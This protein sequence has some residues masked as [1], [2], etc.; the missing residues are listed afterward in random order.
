MTTRLLAAVETPALD[1]W[2]AQIRGVVLGP[3]TAYEWEGKLDGFDE[4]SGLRDADIDRPAG[5][6]AFSMIDYAQP[7]TIAFTLEAADEPDL[8]VSLASAL[9]DL[10]VA[11]APSETAETVPFWYHLPMLGMRRADVKVRRRRVAVDDRYE[12]GVVLVDVQL[13]APDPFLY[14]PASTATTTFAALAGGLEF[15][16]FSD[17]A[18]EDVGYLDFGAPSVTGRMTLTNPGTAPAWPQFRIEGPTPAGGFEIICVDT[19]RT[20]RYVGAVPAGSHVEINPASGTATL[21]DVADRGGQLVR[22]EWFSVP[23][24]KSIEIY[25][26]PIGASTP[27]TLTAAFAP[28]YW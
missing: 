25:F 11:L 26:A 7:R 15:D 28:T 21:D 27:A 22:R 8:G 18:G 16:L 19:G 9:A 12:A 24:G 1:P 2:Q 14:G 10:E 13:T 23:A 6:G 3:G 4:T 17:G 5:H 20:I